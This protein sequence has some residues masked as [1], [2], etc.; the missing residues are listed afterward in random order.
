MDSPKLKNFKAPPIV[1]IVIVLFY[2]WSGEVEI[3]EGD[4]M[5]INIKRIKCTRLKEGKTSQPHTLCQNDKQ[6]EE[7]SAPSIVFILPFVTSWCRHFLDNA[8]S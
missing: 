8:T 5:E 7:V 3:C 4:R 2:F 6:H 1:V